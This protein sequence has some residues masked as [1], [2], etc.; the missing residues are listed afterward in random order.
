MKTYSVAAAAVC[1]A[2]VFSGFGKA[3]ANCADEA[4]DVSKVTVRKQVMPARFELDNWFAADGASFAYTNGAAVVTATDPDFRIGYHWIMPGPPR[5]SGQM[6]ALVLKTDCAYPGMV[7]IVLNRCKSKHDRRE[8]RRVFTAPWACETHFKLDL[9][10]GA[11]Y[12]LAE[13]YFKLDMAAAEVQ[14]G[15]PIQFRFMGFDALTSVSPASALSVDIDT[16]NPQHLV[17]KPGEKAV[18]TLSNL[19][20]REI[21]W[22][23]SLSVEDFFGREIGS[24]FAIALPSG[25]SVRREID[26]RLPKGI[27]FVTVVASSEGSLATNRTSYAK[28]DLHEVTAHQKE[29]E[30]RLGV[31]FHVDRYTPGY[32]RVG[33][34][35]LVAIGAKLARADILHL[36]NVWYAEN[37]VAWEDQEK[38]IDDLYGHGIAIDA[39]MWWPSAEWALIKEPDG[40]LEKSGRRVY[41]PGIMR[42][43][44]EMLAER[45][46]RRIAYYEVGNEWD[47]SKPEWLPYADAVRQTREVAEGVKAKCPSAK[48]IPAGF[49][50]DSSVRHP[51]HVIR[52]MFHEDLMRDVQDVVAAHPV[53]GHGPFKEFA[54]KMR[55]FLQWRKDMGVKIPWY[56]NETAISTTSMRPNDREAAVIMWQK[57]L[58]SWSRGSIDYIW[59]NLRATG[60][61]PDDTE[62][63]FGM[64]TPDFHPRS[65]A[66]SFSALAATFRH[67]ESDGVLFEGD[68]RHVMRFKGVRNGRKV[69]VIAGWDSF[70]FEP[71]AVKVRTD[72]ARAWQVD[73]MGN[74]DAVPVN[75]GV[76]EW[77]IGANPS[78][79][80]LE[81][82]S[83]AEADAKDVSREAKRPVKII[84]PK[85][86]FSEKVEEAD[87]VAKEYEQ[88]YEVFKAMPEHVNR[89]W[90]WW[91]DLWGWTSAA[92]KDGKLTICVTSWDDRHCPRTDDP[93]QG[94]CAL[95][96]LGGWKI[97]LIGGDEPSIKVIE[98]P[99]G[100]AIP[101]DRDW[102]LKWKPG[103]NQNYIFTLDPAA[104]GFGTEIPFNFRLYDNDGLG[105]DGWI[106]YSPLDEEFPSI[107][108]LP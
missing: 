51:S 17:R 20:D 100:A 30:F 9:D 34:D 88:V 19:A 69:R 93:L 77:R 64:F 42:R 89:T 10:P 87:L 32:R 57:V 92:W 13:M 91:E 65:A 47:M 107:I 72:A 106:E 104:L 41:R 99:V 43:Y 63:G 31:N 61:D 81:E 22:D 59:Y 35:A 95:L 55:N 50:A 96:R 52:A 53:H 68:D 40:G 44:G 26:D 97:L 4:S 15:M 66:A 29:G 58:F 76:A 27:R 16:G 1:A 28:I 54:G 14:K 73:T 49:A 101:S 98:K 90:H 60:Y 80:Y 7:T 38:K 103:Y 56:A 45:F 12:Q 85:G 37:N 83:Y 23:V 33:R 25:G 79:F 24:K 105:F 21:A 8:E 5:L 94:D 11:F 74:R 84:V 82:A 108:K 62:Q 18:L 6:F 67:L 78:A 75:D 48:V 36:C 102:S 86:G 46:G 39:I 3:Y 2:I 70:A 71:M